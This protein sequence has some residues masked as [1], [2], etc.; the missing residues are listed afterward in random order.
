MKEEINQRDPRNERSVHKL[1]VE[2]ATK[3][4]TSQYFLI[5]PKLLPDLH[6]NSRMRICCVFNGTH[7]LNP[8]CD[9]SS[10]GYTSVHLSRY[11]NDL[12][13]LNG[14]VP[15]RPRLELSSDLPVRESKRSKLDTN[16]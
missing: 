15:A 11:L 6:Y 14:N 4:N 13:D 9:A 10:L 3:P 5:T 8:R 1:I 7:I 2:T 12:N 16:E